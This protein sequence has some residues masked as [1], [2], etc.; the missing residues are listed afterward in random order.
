MRICMLFDRTL[1]MVGGDQETARAWFKHP[2]RALGG[3]TPLEFADT[4]LGAR[5]V[6]DLLG[7]LK[8]GVFS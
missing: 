2:K 1:E 8:H 5:E 3:K 7:R 4:E 6:E